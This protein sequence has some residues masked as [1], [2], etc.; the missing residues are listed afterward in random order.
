MRLSR[1]ADGNLCMAHFSTHRLIF[2]KNF[3]QRKASSKVI[4]YFK[5]TF[6]Y[7]C[8][9]GLNIQAADF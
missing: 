3:L 6:L 5:Y 4:D 9:L 2:S 1:S 8:D 7:C